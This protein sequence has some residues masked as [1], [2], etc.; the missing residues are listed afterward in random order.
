MAQPISGGYFSTPVLAGY[1]RAVAPAERW[2]GSAM[3]ERIMSDEFDSLNGTEKAAA[4]V[5]LIRSRT[6][7]AKIANELRNKRPEHFVD[8]SSLAELYASLEHAARLLEQKGR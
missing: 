2:G 5:A 7:A 4:E 6:L 1:I 3:S 8:K